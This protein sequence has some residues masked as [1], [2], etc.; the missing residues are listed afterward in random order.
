VRACCQATHGVEEPCDLCP[1]QLAGVE[2][3][4]VL[5]LFYMAAD[6]RRPDKNT[7]GRWGLA[8]DAIAL[9][10]DTYGVTDKPR[11]VSL[12]QRACAIMNGEYDL[13]PAGPAVVP[14]TDEV[15]EE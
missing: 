13:A 14:I 9:A 5:R 2:G 15:D 7:P 3:M 1:F 6:K 8:R 11:A 12:M 4:T 10:L